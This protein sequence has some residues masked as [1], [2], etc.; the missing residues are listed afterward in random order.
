MMIT[1]LMKTTFL[2]FGIIGTLNFLS[3]PTSEARVVGPTS[4]ATY[5]W[6]GGYVQLSSVGDARGLSV[7]IDWEGRVKNGASFTF[8]YPPTGRNVGITISYKTLER[9]I[10]SQ[11]VRALRGNEVYKVAFPDLDWRGNL[12]DDFVL[13]LN[14]D[15]ELVGYEYE[16]FWNNSSR[17]RIE[18]RIEKR[19]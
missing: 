13:W 11:Q 9:E 12:K 17:G 19:Y 8:Y 10:D 4:A 1:N 14:K 6:P 18:A 3:I 5:L 15:F 2:F 16:E 7:L